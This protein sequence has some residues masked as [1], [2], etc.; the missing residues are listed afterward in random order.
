MRGEEGEAA[1]PG[2]DVGQRSRHDGG[3]DAAAAHLQRQLQL[4]PRK[5]L[6]LER[7]VVPQVSVRRSAEQRVRGRDELGDGAKHV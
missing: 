1:P 5:P 3:G 6:V 4:Q 2:R 7:E